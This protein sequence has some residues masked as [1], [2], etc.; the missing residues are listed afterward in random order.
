M[1]KIKQAAEEWW[2][3]HY[4]SDDMTAVENGFIEG[5]R[6]L[7]A[8]AEKIKTEIGYAGFRGLTGE[9]LHAFLDT[10]EFVLLS[11]LRKLFEEE[12]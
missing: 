9:P 10:K 11:D 1:S 6:F 5:A 4:D 2:L 7:L 3:S 12:K 8:E